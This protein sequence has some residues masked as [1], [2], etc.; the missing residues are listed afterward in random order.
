MFSNILAANDKYPVHYRGKLTIPIQRQ[1]DKKQIIFSQFFAALLKSKLDSE[2][3][4]K[5][6]TL[7]DSA[8]PKLQTPKMWLDKCLK[9]PVSEDPLTSNMVN[10]SKHC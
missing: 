2:H 1:L 5:K 9:S 4:G 3:F 8:F 10:R 6:M 7:I